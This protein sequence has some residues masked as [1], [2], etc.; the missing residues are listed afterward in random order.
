MNTKTN[1]QLLTL[2]LLFIFSAS[3]QSQCTVHTRDGGDFS[4]GLCPANTPMGQTFTACS[5]GFVTSIS[6]TH[7]QSFLG[8]IGSAGTYELYMTVEPGAGLAVTATHIVATE[9]VPT[10]PTVGQVLTFNLTA[11]FP[12]QNDG[13][14]YRFVAT[15][16]TGGSVLAFQTGDDFAG[17][18]VMDHANNFIAAQDIDFGMVIDPGNLVPTLSEWGLI[19]L[20]LLIMNIIMLYIA[21]PVVMLSSGHTI[22]QEV[23]FRNLPFKQS[24]YFKILINVAVLAL[25]VFTASILLFGYELTSADP[26][27]VLISIPILSYLVMLFILEK[28]KA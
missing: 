22:K 15:N 6:L 7:S 12:V 26:F 21:S 20:A 24:S 17:G 1:L 14:L 4:S 3:L 28:E 8:D 25:L 13:T 23:S 16:T 5:N 27:G 9:V 11:P 10:T 19:I 18:G 2:F